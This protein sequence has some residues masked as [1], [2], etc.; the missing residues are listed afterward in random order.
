MNCTFK[1]GVAALMLA[2][3]G[4]VAAGPF[5]D[6]TAAYEKRR[7]AG[8]VDRFQWF[9]PHCDAPLHE[10]AAEVL[11]YRSDPVSKAYARFFDSEDFRTCRACGHVMPRPGM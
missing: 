11:D 7:R 1:A 4:S 10:E 9:C 6:A 2:V 3:A 5:E 8:E